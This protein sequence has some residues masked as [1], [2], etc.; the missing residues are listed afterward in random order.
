MKKLYILVLLAA[1]LGTPVLANGVEQNDEVETEMQQITITVKGEKGDVV[2]ICNAQG[3]KLE[4][5]NLA[6]FRVNIIS[7]ENEEATMKLN[8]PKGYYLLKVGKVVRKISIR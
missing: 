3:M 7:I 8:I 4:I 6:G 2:K 1:F 5:Y